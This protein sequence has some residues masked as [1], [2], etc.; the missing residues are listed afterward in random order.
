MRVAVL[1]T[2]YPRHPEDAVGRFVASAVE[3]VR[4]RGIEVDVVGPAQ[5]RGFG[6]TYGYGI[7]GNV[8]R[9]P[10]LEL[11]VPALLASFV[12]GARRVASDLL[13]GHGLP[14]GW[15]ASRT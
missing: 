3:N 6:L 11:S 10:W 2:S 9:R 13:H 7:I 4:A 14:G 5:F 1:T 12:R 15:G 8:R